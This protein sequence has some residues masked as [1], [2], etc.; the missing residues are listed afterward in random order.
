MVL[1]RA[2]GRGWIKTVWT[3]SMSGFLYL[4]ILF[5]IILV[6]VSDIVWKATG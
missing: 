3:A 5:T 2:Y 1:K 6:V 4:T